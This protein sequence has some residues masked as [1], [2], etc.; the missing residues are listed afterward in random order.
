MPI[1]PLEKTFPQDPYRCQGVGPSGQCEFRAEEGKRY[2]R[3]HGGGSAIISSGKQGTYYDLDETEYLRKFSD[4]VNMLGF[5]HQSRSLRSEVGILRATLERLLKTVEDDEGLQFRSGELIALTAKIESL[6][7]TSLVLE[8]ELGQ[9]MSLEEAKQIAGEL[10]EVLFKELDA[11]K[12]READ[13]IEQGK[14]LI[15]RILIPDE[16]RADLL[17]FMEPLGIQRSLENIAD[18]FGDIV[19]G[20]NSPGHKS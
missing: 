20:K 15:E 8:K 14:Q 12:D 1:E 17:G 9:L 4:R 11:L 10:L 16:I 19:S 6:E 3:L 5:S 7:K 13:R 18:A 2:C